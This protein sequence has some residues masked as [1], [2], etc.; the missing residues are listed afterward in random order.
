MVG[1]T[2]T[3]VGRTWDISLET[4][5]EPR[6]INGRLKGYFCSDV[7]FNLSNKVLSDLEKLGFT[8]PPSFINESDL[9][10]DFEDFARKIRCKWY[11][12]NDVT[13]SFSQLPAFRNKSNWNPPKGHSTLEMF[14]SQ[15]EGDIFSVLPG[16]TS[17]YNLTKNEWLAMRGLAEN[18][19]IIITLAPNGLNILSLL[20][21]LY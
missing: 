9:K 16:N 18:R 8:P 5:I 21:T 3:S 20:V 4:T 1:S 7:V 2:Q 6:S 11:F 14:L 13:E 12:R 17:S 15:L 10:R 19:S